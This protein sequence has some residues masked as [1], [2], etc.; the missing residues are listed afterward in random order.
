MSIAVYLTINKCIV[1]F[2]SILYVIVNVF[3]VYKLSNTYLN[4][5]LRVEQFWL[6]NQIN[7][8][9]DNKREIRKQEKSQEK[10]RQGGL[11]V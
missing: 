8:G 4:M 9:K 5:Y 10:S 7:I 11:G 6:N 1:L 3:V 2:L